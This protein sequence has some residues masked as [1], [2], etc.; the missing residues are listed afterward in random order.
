LA[1]L[2]YDISKCWHR[3]KTPFKWNEG[4]DDD[5][6][7]NSLM[8]TQKFEDLLLNIDENIDIDNCVDNFE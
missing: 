8:N 6:R 7:N 2:E 5:V 1:Y 4:Y 3:M